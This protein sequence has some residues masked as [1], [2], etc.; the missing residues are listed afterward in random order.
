MIP[1]PHHP[2]RC[3]SPTPTRVT[4]V[5]S[6]V[7]AESAGLGAGDG[8]E[9]SM[10]KKSRCAANRELGSNTHWA[11]QLA[12]ALHGVMERGDVQ[13]AGLARWAWVD[14]GKMVT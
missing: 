6:V 5:G 2:P 11:M 12:P 14:P 1:T 7:E 10:I 4:R 8:G 3:E 13:D 9:G